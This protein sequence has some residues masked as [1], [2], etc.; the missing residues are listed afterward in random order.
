[1]HCRA[2]LG[3]YKAYSREEQ[4]VVT[5]EAFKEAVQK[6]ESEDYL[7]ALRYLEPLLKFNDVKALGCYDEAFMLIK[8]WGPCEDEIPIFFLFMASSFSNLERNEEA[9]DCAEKALN[10]NPDESTKEQLKGILEA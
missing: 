7:E 2:D 6:Y 10:M 4:E 3:K 1:M 9:K 8:E 5:E